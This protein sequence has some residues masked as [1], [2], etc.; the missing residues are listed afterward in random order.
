MEDLFGSEI[1]Q[2]SKYVLFHDES[3]CKKTNFLYHGFLFIRNKNGREILEK[4]KEIKNS[5]IKEKKEIHF[6][7]LNQHS[8]S[9]YGAKTKVAL[10]WL[11]NTKGWLG[12]GSVL[13]YCFGV[14]KNN[15]KNFWTKPNS[16]E[17]NVYLRFFEMGMKAA[18]R[19]FNLD[20]ITHTF[21]DSGKYDKDRQKRVCWLNSN[22]FNS[23]LSHEVSPK[24]TRPLDSDENKSNSEFSNFIQLCDVL[25]GV[26]RSSFC[27]L[28]D[29]QKGQ[30]E[31]VDNFIDVIERFN[32][33]RKAYNNH[34]RYWKKFCIQFFPSSNN[35]TKKEFLSGDIDTIIKKGKLFYCDRKTYRGKIAEK[36]QTKLF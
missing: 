10:E 36:S 1:D 12:K 23:R 35:L 4:I 5:H 31:C 9:P 29:N 26:V 11:D 18:I 7:R 8:G 14:D 34:S 20:N 30:K 22:F 15:L 13:F 33:K 6:E 24:N 3:D 2:T 32:N 28:S 19:W 21:L 27:E 25:L 17:K 16:Y